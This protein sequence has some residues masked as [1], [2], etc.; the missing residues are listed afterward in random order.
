[1]MRRATFFAVLAHL[2]AIEPQTITAVDCDSRL[3]SLMPVVEDAK[4]S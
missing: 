1:M 3:V 2:V 4:I